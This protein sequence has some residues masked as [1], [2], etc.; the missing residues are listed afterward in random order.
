[1]RA[2]R[3]KKRPDTSIPGRSLTLPFDAQPRHKGYTVVKRSHCA[4]MT[5]SIYFKATGDSSIK[6][7]SF[8]AFH[9]SDGLPM[10]FLADFRFGIG[11]SA[12]QFRFCC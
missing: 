12:R 10:L 2:R 3:D 9:E 4:F 1:M 5:A 8:A 7:P 11:I 6:A